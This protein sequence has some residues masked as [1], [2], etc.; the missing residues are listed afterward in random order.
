M[1]PERR[2]HPRQRTHGH[3]H[4]VETNK[5]ARD[6][7]I[8]IDNRTT[9]QSRELPISRETNERIQSALAGLPVEQTVFYI[10]LDTEGKNTGVVL[11]IALTNQEGTTKHVFA[12][13][14]QESNGQVARI[15][16]DMQPDNQTFT[17]AAHYAAEDALKH[18]HLPT[19]S[20]FASPSAVR[21]NP[22]CTTLFQIHCSNP[23]EPQVHEIHAYRNPLAHTEE[24]EDQP[25]SLMPLI[26]QPIVDRI[27]GQIE[28]LNTAATQPIPLQL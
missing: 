10:Q 11:Y 8:H 1:S 9:G 17:V 22:Q 25:V 4:E 2:L 20:P 3:A 12:I 18:I 27:V 7:R 16:I 5:R 28:V 24:Q 14:P 19:D 13:S 26:Y 21:I 6:R 15:E 23:A